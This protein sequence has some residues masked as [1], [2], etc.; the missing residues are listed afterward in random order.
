[1]F[2][3]IKYVTQGYLFYVGLVASVLIGVVL[4]NRI[5]RDIFK[6]KI[7][8]FT[9]TIASIGLI[10]FNVFLEEFDFLAKAL[11][12]DYGIG[13]F[14][15][16]GLVLV[17]S[18][19][20]IV[21]YNMQFIAN[22]S[23]RIFAP[24]RKVGPIFKIG[25]RYPAENASRTGITLVMFA[26][27]VYLV[28]FVSIEK[29]AV[30]DFSQ[31][32]LD[33]SLNGYDVIVIP[34]E[35]T[36]AEIVAMQE[37]ITE[38]KGVEDVESST[39][40]QII[41]PEYTYG[42]LPESPYFGDTSQLPDYEDEDKFQTRINSLTPDL[43]KSTE[44]ELGEY[45]ERYENPEEVWDALINED[46]KVVLGSVF[47]S[48]GFGKRP[49]IELGEK[50]KVA[51]LFNQTTIEK[52]VIGKVAQDDI[53][54]GLSYGLYQNIVTSTNDVSNDF[55]EE[56]RSQLSS[57]NIV[58]KIEGNEN[59]EVV[60]AIKK[61]IIDYNILIVLDVEEVGGVQIGF[62]NSMMLM[63]QGFLAFSLIVGTSGLAIILVRSVNER[64]Q[65]I[66]MLRSLGFQRR[67]ILASFFVEA[68]FITFMGIVIGI[69]M[70]IISAQSLF[71]I[72]GEQ[73]AEIQLIIPWGEIL[74]ISLLIYIASIIF[75]FLPSIK[76]ANLSPVE[77]TNYPE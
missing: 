60:N 20:L 64:R 17:I 42:E 5:A 53:G 66:G 2:E 25:L 61:A 32:I 67:M 3:D 41:L 37:E 6:K 31:S 62:L 18:S 49:D 7:D 77:A 45:L 56:Y 54:A 58:V 33:K 38:V 44:V 12:T 63:L 13:I 16:V 15:I 8:R 10:T 36:T 21:T 73:N 14:F 28:G 75:S 71:A 29:A 34:S 48:Q 76:A 74:I 65:Q 22:T 47:V 59:G 1:M 40:T 23:S 30:N 57:T 72:A 24:L 46:D 35:A 51:D 4:I 50:I 69:S 70:G 52:E 26:I 39:E 68:T 43:L 19:A 11:N 9:I 27:I 55:T